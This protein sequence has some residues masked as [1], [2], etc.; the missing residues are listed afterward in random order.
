MN[1][2]N[3]IKPWGSYTIL[4]QHANITAKI[5]MVNCSHRTSLQYHQNRTEKWYILKGNGIAELD[6]KHKMVPGSELFIPKTK[7]H[8]ITAITDLTFLEISCGVFEECDIVRIEDDYSRETQSTQQ[9]RKY[10]KF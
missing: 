8:R 4:S 6:G 9:N 1:K 5:I 3:M 10:N 2:K 7:P